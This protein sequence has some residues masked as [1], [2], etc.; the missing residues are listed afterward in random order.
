[1]RFFLG[2]KREDCERREKEGNVRA[3]SQRAQRESFV[4]RVIQV[5]VERTLIP[6][7]CKRLVTHDS[8]VW[9]TDSSHVRR[10]GRPMTT[11][12][13]NVTSCNSLFFM[14]LSSFLIVFPEFLRTP[15]GCLLLFFFGG[16]ALTCRQ[17]LRSPPG[18]AH[19]Q[20]V[21]GPQELQEPQGPA[22]WAAEQRVRQEQREQEW[23]LLWY[24]RRAAE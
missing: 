6:A 22:A 15:G 21:P 24:G 5:A 16:E 23:S 4:A 14:F 1:M 19:S 11:C 9:L 10:A 20:R 8:H 2:A 12:S 13:R 17:G 3:E 7:Q 18:Q